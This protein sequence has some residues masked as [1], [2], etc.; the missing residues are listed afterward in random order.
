MRQIAQRPRRRHTGR[1]AH[2]AALPRAL[3]CKGAPEDVMDT[4]LLRLGLEAQIE[5]VPALGEAMRRCLKGRIDIL[6]VNLMSFTGLELTA[7]AAFR[8]LMPSALIVGVTSQE[9]KRPLLEAGVVDEVFVPYEM[10]SVPE[11]PK[12]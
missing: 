4:C 10:E 9:M 1:A 2:A 11:G 12:A 3:I 6:L 5:H 7:L 8:D